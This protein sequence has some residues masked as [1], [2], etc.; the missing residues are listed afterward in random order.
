M[1]PLYLSGQYEAGVRRWLASLTLKQT[2][3]VQQ[4]ILHLNS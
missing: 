1:P 4:Q 2:K 3:S